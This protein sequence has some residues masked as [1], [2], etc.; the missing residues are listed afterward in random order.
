MAITIMVMRLQF[1]RLKSKKTI[2]VG[3]VLIA[4]IVA[5]GFVLPKGTVKESQTTVKLDKKFYAQKDKA[6]LDS[7]NRM[8]GAII[9]YY[10]VQNL[11]FPE[12]SERG[13]GQAI[14]DIGVSESFHDPYTGNIY[15]FTGKTPGYNEVMYGPGKACSKNGKSFVAGYG[16]KSL[17]LIAKLSDGSHCVNNYQGNEN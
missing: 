17:A 3:I 4:A 9:Y 15:Q 6:K 10:N 16:K 8:L 5:G 7:L 11:D 2:A 12:A 13:W 1:S 14:D